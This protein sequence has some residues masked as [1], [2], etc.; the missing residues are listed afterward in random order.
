MTHRSARAELRKFAD[1]KQAKNLQRFFKTAK[2]EYGY[3]DI[4][5][6]LKVPQV[7]LITKKFYDL[8]LVE[9]EKL[10]KSKIHEERQCALFIL[11]D[12]FKKGDEKLRRRVV[13]VYLKNTKF[14]NN[15]DLVDLSA[16][17]I[18]GAF[19][20]EQNK[21]VKVNKVART[22]LIKLAKS[23][24]LW[25]RRIAMLACF[26]FIKNKKFDEALVIAELLLIDK[27][28]LIHKAVGWMLR[29]IGNR[30][31]PVEEIFLKKHFK[32]MPRVMLRYAIEKFGEGDRRRYLGG[33]R[34]AGSL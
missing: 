14:I 26:Y 18:L 7:R 11:E 20:F 17:N 34:V 9:V 31:R 23:K 8:P 2:G 33:S 22:Q 24:S 32:K 25:E 3:G 12:K 21:N 16:P 15:W 10:L 1:K 13:E 5:L 27:H 4:F 6:G 29:E 28:D 19:L 30:A